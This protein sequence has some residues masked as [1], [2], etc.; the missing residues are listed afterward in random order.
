MPTALA[1]IIARLQIALDDATATFWTT[2][3]LT[4][5]IQR[6]LRDISHHIPLEKKSALTTVASN[7]ELSIATL[8]PRIGIVA[9]EYKTGAWPKTF[10]PFSVWGDTLTFTGDTVPDGANADIYWH[11]Q[12]T[13]NGT[14]TLSEDQDE[15]LLFGAAAFACDQQVADATNQLTAGGPA[16]PRDWR[17]L[18]A[19]F[20]ARYEDRLKPRRGIRTHSMFAPQEPLPT[21]DTDPGP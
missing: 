14:K 17:S 4:E 10:Q 13:I 19:S 12:H 16:T 7:R 21:Q 18:A 20:R 11:G 1:T 2:A 15:T 6:A 5:H 9:V 8:T 3:E